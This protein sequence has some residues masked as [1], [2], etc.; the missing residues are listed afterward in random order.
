[1]TLYRKDSGKIWWVDVTDPSGKRHRIS[2]K[3]ESKQ[4]AQA[5][6]DKFRMELWKEAQLGIQRDHTLAEAIDLFLKEKRKLRSIATYEER[7]GWWKDQLGQRPVREVTQALIAQ[8]AAKLD[9][10]V[11]PSTINRYLASLRAVMRLVALKYQWI[12]RVPTFFLHKEPKGRTRWLRPEE[13]GRLLAELPPHRRDIAIFSLATGLRQ[14]NVRNLKWSQV[15]LGRRV[16]MIDGGEMK[17]GRDHAIP[18][19][20][21]A[22]EVIKRQIGQHATHVFTYMGKPIKSSSN[23]VWKEACR[24]AG[25]EDF[26]QHDMRHTWASTLV[27]SGVPDN[28]LQALGAWETPK[29]VQRY[30]HHAADSLRPYTER[31]DGVLSQAVE[32]MGSPRQ[33]PFKL[34]R[35][36]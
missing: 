29:M 10:E 26:R 9:G 1:M 33:T 36:A 28:V 27:Q 15:D 30:A 23:E 13:M 14:G 16:L 31:M 8:T 24:R 25:I 3:T 18:L 20:D 22:V 17:A 2:T 12:E 34:R 5:F 35:V 19:P 11:T 6:H 32:Q 21:V 7:L 4:L